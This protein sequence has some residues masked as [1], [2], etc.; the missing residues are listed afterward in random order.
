M[1]DGIRRQLVELRSDHPLFGAG[2]VF[3]QRAGQA[4]FQPAVQ[5][6]LLQ[7]AE[8]PDGHVEYPGLVVAQIG[9]FRTVL[10]IVTM[11]C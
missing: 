2:P 5:Q 9:Q 11:G 6:F 1:A 10:V 7:R 4:F 8:L 3:D